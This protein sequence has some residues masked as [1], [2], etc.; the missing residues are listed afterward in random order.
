MPVLASVNLLTFSVCH[1]TKC[2][3][4]NSVILPYMCATMCVCLRVSVC[5]C[6]CVRERERET[7]RQRQRKTEIERQRQKQRAR[8]I[9]EV[10]GTLCTAG[11]GTFY[12]AGSRGF[13]T[14]A[15]GS[16]CVSKSSCS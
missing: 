4:A 5:V 6:M 13:C 2:Q 11:S 10:S 7:D 14:V 8:E 16:T 15:R 3:F 12:A 9:T 1:F